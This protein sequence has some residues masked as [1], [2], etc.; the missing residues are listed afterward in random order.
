MRRRLFVFWA[1][2]LVIFPLAG[3]LATNSLRIPH[4]FDAWLWAVLVVLAV[5]VA[6]RTYLDLQAP[7]SASPDEAA[8]TTLRF[9]GGRLEVSDVRIGLFR[10]GRRALIVPWSEVQDVRIG[11]GDDWQGDHAEAVAFAGCLLA[12]P[13]PRSSLLTGGPGMSSFVPGI[14]R[15]VIVD[16]D[17]VGVK[18]HAVVAALAKHRP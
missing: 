8:K 3:N 18:R 15:L 17:R 6:F 12:R 9:W 10:W 7:H 11:L 4:Q 2:V 14:D 1:L 13:L 5:L 16:L